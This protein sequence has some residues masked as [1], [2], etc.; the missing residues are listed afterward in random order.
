MVEARV[1]EGG[2][3][4]SREVIGDDGLVSPDGRLI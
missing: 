4:M 2:R 1:L 3:L